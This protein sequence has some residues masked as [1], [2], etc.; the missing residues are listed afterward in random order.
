MCRSMFR[1]LRGGECCAKNTRSRP[2]PGAVLSL[3][4]SLLPHFSDGKIEELVRWFMAMYIIRIIV[5][6][7]QDDALS[8]RISL[9]RMLRGVGY[10]FPCFMIYSVSLFIPAGLGLQLL[11]D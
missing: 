9:K 11:D 7:L 3:L 10:D 2:C 6:P 4:S 5:L 1:R 8:V